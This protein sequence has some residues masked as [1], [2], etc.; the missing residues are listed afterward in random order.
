M[1]NE[2]Y[3]FI[4]LVT[5]FSFVLLAHRFFGK[6]GLQVW[7]SIATIT[8][9]LE[10]LK[11]V[12]LFGVQATLGTIMFGSIF[13]AT[14]IMTECYGAK[15]ARQSV[16]MSFFC[17]VAFLVCMQLTL[18][19]EPNAIDFADAPMR[20]LMTINLRVTGASLLMFLIANLCDVAM[21]ENLRQRTNGKMIW[22]RNNLSTMTCNCLEN[23]FF[24][25]LG[26]Y[27][28]FDFTQCMEIALSTTLIEVIISLCD[29]PFLYLSLR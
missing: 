20:E 8:A 25:F 21:Y 1:I 26:F 14:D 18:I 9:N 4:E 28:L 16:L 24:V 29:T 15:E 10:T 13:L 3:F 6:V 11:S 22:L 27:G 2:Y 19:Y 12:D 17:S 5:V 23:F 7:T